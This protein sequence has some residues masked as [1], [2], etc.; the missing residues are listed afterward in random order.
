VSGDD[1]EEPHGGE[2][3]AQSERDRGIWQRG[4]R[5]TRRH[6][7]IRSRVLDDRRIGVSGK[8][9]ALAILILAG[10]SLIL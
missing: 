8:D 6:D 5:A 2:H 9:S 10:R 3:A 4:R 7:A 1:E